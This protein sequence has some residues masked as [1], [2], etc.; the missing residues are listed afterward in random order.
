MGRRDLLRIDAKVEV[1]YKNFDQFYKEYTKNIS[2]GGLFIK[3]DN[4][5]KQQTVLE[6]SIKIPGTEN[7]LKLIGEVVHVI[8]PEMA[9][10]HGW[11][12]GI[13]VHFVDFD[14]G[15][16]RQVEAY[17]AR[18]YKDNPQAR[19]A[20]RRKHERVSMRLRVKFPSLDVLIHDYSED[21]SHGGIF[22]QTQKPRN[23]GDNLTIT[24]VHPDTGQELEL[25]G[26][27]VRVTKQ[28]AHVPGSAPGM[29]IKFT[30]LDEN[31]RQAIN[32]FLGLAL[33]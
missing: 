15:V 8:E 32:K 12:A 17:V 16:Q 23:I 28:E 1:E 24:L 9:K 2:K 10:A 4:V 7:T 5:M 30:D 21:I 3:T 33:S 18:L 29:G 27:V 13:G 31:K 22:I 11:E 6:V 25:K 19:A 14:E 20:D 26:V